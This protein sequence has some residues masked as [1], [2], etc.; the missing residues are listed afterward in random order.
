M[1]PWA[2]HCKGYLNFRKNV[3]PWRQ[4]YTFL[5]FFRYLKKKNHCTKWLQCQMQ[6]A[7]LR[8]LRIILL[9][10][11][12]FNHF[13]FGP[14]GCFARMFKR[15]FCSLDMRRWYLHV[16]LL[17]FF[18]TPSVWFCSS[19]SRKVIYCCAHTIILDEWYFV[20]RKINARPSVKEVLPAQ[21]KSLSLLQ[22][23]Q[24]T[25]VPHPKISAT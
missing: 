5:H 7:T 18:F 1:A 6:A 20:N 13:L 9:F 15:S 23:H 17:L 21:S 8:L 19:I 14:P 24:P 11:F 12:F 25:T 3:Y 2:L 16:F 4:G 22:T 10:Y